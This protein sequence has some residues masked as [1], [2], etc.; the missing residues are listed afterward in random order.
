MKRDRIKS[1]IKQKK[2]LRRPC[3]AVKKSKP[4]REVRKCNNCQVK[5]KKT[6]HSGTCGSV[7]NIMSHG[8]SQRKKLT[9]SLTNA[10]LKSMSSLKTS[11]EL[12]EWIRR[13]RRK[14]AEW[15]RE[16][17]KRRCITE[18]LRTLAAHNMTKHPLSNKNST[19]KPIKRLKR[20]KTRVTIQKNTVN[21]DDFNVIKSKW[22]FSDI[23]KL[24][25]TTSL[26]SITS[27]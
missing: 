1:H 11:T 20:T 6:N 16:V 5:N 22:R 18:D 4:K 25:E 2:A 19:E 13:W 21:F 9:S 26:I 3:K 15:Q 8:G 12:R 27:S 23:K 24:D 17:P 7:S 10:S 14:E